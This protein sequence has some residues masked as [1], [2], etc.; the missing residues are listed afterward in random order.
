MKIL[1]EC[2]HGIGDVVMTLPAL[3]NLRAIYPDAR[4]VYMGGLECERALLMHTGLVDDVYIYN[5]RESGIPDLI[6]LGCLFLRVHFDLG[7]SFGGSPR[8]LDVLFLK[9]AGCKKIVAGK[10]PHAVYKRYFQV[11][12]PEETHRVRQF[13]ELI[14]KIG[15]SAAIDANT[16]QIDPVF[17]EQ[18]MQNVHMEGSGRLIGLVLGTGDFMYRE[19][20]AIVSYNTKKW[21]PEKFA[22]LARRLMEAGFR[23]VLFG[24]EKEK[25]DC[26]RTD[27]DFPKEAVSL[28]GRTSLLEMTAVM[29]RCRMVIGGDTG[30]MHCAAAA[31][32][33]TLTLFGPTDA[34]LIGPYGEHA[35]A[36]YGDGSCI[37]CYSKQNEKGRTCHPANCMQAI[38]VDAVYRT[39]LESIGEGGPLEKADVKWTGF[40]DREAVD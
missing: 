4:I 14:H 32:V 19:G 39:V 1:V 27:V 29:T 5:V 35:H 26:S 31:G 33:P 22:A 34:E 20:T 6:K 7:I 10:N 40:R 30:P 18:V 28:L 17:A 25:M 15:G 2:H 3:K 37:K 13:A 16:I 38:S 24:G 23:I 36:M 11:D 8:G 12:V 21:S 9:L